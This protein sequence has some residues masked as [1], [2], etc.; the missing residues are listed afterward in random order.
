MNL[1]ACYRPFSN[2]DQPETVGGLR[3]EP[4]AQNHDSHN[5]IYFRHSN[6]RNTR[7]PIRTLLSDI[8]GDCGRVA[9]LMW[10]V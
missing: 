10:V 2:D 4:V 6:T 3:L 7:R 8:S 9:V 1:N 5:G